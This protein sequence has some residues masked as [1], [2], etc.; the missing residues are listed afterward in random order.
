MSGIKCSITIM[1]FR[2][3]LQLTSVPS[4]VGVASHSETQTLYECKPHGGNNKPLTLF[5]KFLDI[6]VANGSNRSIQRANQILFMGA[7]IQFRE[8]TRFRCYY[9]VALA[10]TRISLNFLSPYPSICPVVLRLEHVSQP[11]AHTHYRHASGA[12]KIYKDSE[13][14]FEST[15]TRLLCL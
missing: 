8:R 3:E 12:G 4:L 15:P 2:N 7:T 6:T 10:I 13:S 9:T 11:L 5:D 1:A 14:F